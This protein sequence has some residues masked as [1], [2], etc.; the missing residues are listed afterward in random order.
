MFLRLCGRVCSEG[1]VQGAYVCYIWDV[2]GGMT[3]LWRMA[4]NVFFQFNPLLFS[5]I[6]CKG[7]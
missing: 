1:A 2:Q 3:V 7:L 6:A 4:W 5:F